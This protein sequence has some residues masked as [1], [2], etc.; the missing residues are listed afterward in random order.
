M[1]VARLEDLPLVTG[2]GNFAGD[3]SFQHQLHMRVVRSPCAH[4]HVKAI[5]VAEAR[6]LPGVIAVWTAD[7]IADLPPIDFREGPNERLA[8]FRQPVLAKDYVRFAGEPLAAIFATDPYV[9]EDAADL[10]NIEI[11]ELDAVIDAAAQPSEFDGALTTEPT[12]CRQSY[13]DVAVAFKDA[14]A[15][16]ELD[17]SVGRHSGVPLETRG[18]IG[19]YDAG[20]DVLELHGAA[21]VPHKN[22]ESLARMLGRSPAG[23]HLY[24]GH[25]GGGFGVRGEIY[26]EDILVLVAR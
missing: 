7:D 25:V 18:A 23:I 24:E 20:R 21:K 22:R 3:V 12:I 8:P 26:P 19:R 2:R 14:A 13:G 1:S 10:I 17:L 6:A 9:A 11:G 16:V 15:I 4:G 5:D